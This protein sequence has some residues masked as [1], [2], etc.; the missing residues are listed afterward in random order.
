MAI[1]Q[2]SEE[3]STAYGYRK[4]KRLN[5]LGL[6]MMDAQFDK[7]LKK[8]MKNAT[9]VNEY[10]IATA[11]VLY[12]FVGPR[13]STL[14]DKYLVWVA[15]RKQQQQRVKSYLAGYLKY[16]ETIHLCTEELKVC[17]DRYYAYIA[18]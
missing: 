12:D 17:T 16:P 1:S 18:L 13:F 7:V 15:Y 14:C 6:S 8:L 3:G 9:A 11:M 10:T 4:E 2:C 5:Y